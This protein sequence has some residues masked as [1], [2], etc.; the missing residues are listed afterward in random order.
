VSKLNLKAKE[1]PIYTAE[2]ARAVRITPTQ[3][4]RRSVLACMLWENNFYEDGQTIGE[5]ISALVPQVPAETV[6]ELAIE[7]RTR[8]NL[9]HV[10]LLLA[11]ELAKHKTHRHVVGALVPKIVQRADELAEIL[12]IYSRER[13]GT[14]KLNRLSKQ[15]QKGLAEAFRK[16]SAYNLAKYNRDNTIKLRD[17]LFL[18][19]AKPKDEEQEKTWKLLVNGELP[20]PDTWEVAI[21]AAKGDVERTKA[22]WERLLKDDRLGALALIRNLRNMTRAKVD[23]GLVR[24]AL[25]KADTSRVLPFRFVAAA[26]AA[27]EFESELDELLVKSAR[28]ASKLPGHTVLIVDVSGSMYGY[29]NI[30]ARSDITRVQAAGAL[31][32][33]A[34]ERCESVSIYATAGNDG[35]YRHATALVP[36]RHGMALVEKFSKNGFAGE[37]GSGGIFLVQALDWVSERE[38][39]GA[40]RIIVFTD[41]QD[42]DRKSTI[43]TRASKPSE[44]NAFGRRANYLINISS[45]KNGIGY[46]PNWTHLDGFSEA[47]LD[48]IGASEQG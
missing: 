48:Y 1:E 35:S 17:V 16:F 30:S 27:P 2:G 29:G 25:L 28:Q 37:L 46:K 21:S 5:R 38:T 47:V 23:R 36:S 22:T 11:C 19:H 42:C 13:S 8:G 4:L 9:R 43:C 41:E 39:S 20:T 44:A 7:A 33:V 10:P 26:V 24:E 34:R 6:A 31:A 15:L 12:A 14:K 32:A 40:D 45:N 18:T 3:Q